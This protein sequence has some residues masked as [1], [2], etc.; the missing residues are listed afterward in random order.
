MYFFRPLSK[1]FY[2]LAL[3]VLLG[4]S[5]DTPQLP[6]LAPDAVILAFGDSLTYGTGASASDSYPAVLQRLTG[7][8]VVNAGVRGELT[9]QGLRRLPGLLDAHKPALLILCHGGN[10]MLRLRDNQRIAANLR[11]M[12]REARARGIQVLLVAVPAPGVFLNGAGFY[13][14]IAG[15]FGLPFVA[16][17]LP[18]LIADSRMK[19]DPIHLN[20]E[21]YRML[22]QAVYRT[23]QR[24]GM[25]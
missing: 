18:E 22:S 20:R 19:S 3:L 6:R 5:P 11:A 10:D 4:C 21:G 2:L 8:K 15:E 17:T 9:A 12:I 7:R 13:E 23:L 16:D 25:L 24:H 14:D 1:Q